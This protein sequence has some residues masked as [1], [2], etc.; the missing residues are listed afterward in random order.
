MSYPANQQDIARAL[1]NAIYGYR[2]LYGL[3][4]REVAAVAE[5]KQ[6]TVSGIELG[7]HATSLPTFLAIARGL[8]IRPAELIGAV[9]AELRKPGPPR[10]A[11]RGRPPKPRD[12]GQ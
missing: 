7:Q 5:V 11:R 6:A 9:M 3:T 8:G 1:G 12:D 4:Q 10:V 2:I